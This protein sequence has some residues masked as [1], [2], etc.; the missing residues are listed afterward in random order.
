[1]NEKEIIAVVEA[2]LSRRGIP[3]S[4]KIEIEIKEE[5]FSPSTA[6]QE[7]ILGKIKIGLREFY[8]TI[9]TIASSPFVKVTLWIV[10]AGI[11]TFGFYFPSEYNQAKELAINSTM[12]IQ[13]EYFDLRDKDEG[14]YVII[15]PEWKDSEEA[16]NADH[17]RYLANLPTGSYSMPLSAYPD[18]FHDAGLIASGSYHG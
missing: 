3:H 17:I 4:D 18:S 7:T 15:N 12:M 13:Q 5:S 2:E 6:P 11:P 1:M 9:K 8:A 16:Y 10:F 14:K